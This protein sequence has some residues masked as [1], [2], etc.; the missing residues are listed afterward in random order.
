MEP[1]ASVVGA[2]RIAEDVVGQGKEGSEVGAGRRVRTTT[3]T[4]V[5]S[6]RLTLQRTMRRLAGGVGFLSLVAA[7]IGLGSLQRLAL[8]ERATELALRRA[9]GA[10][11]VD[12]ATLLLLETG[13]ITATAVML[14]TI[15]TLVG[16]AGLA[17]WSTWPVEINWTVIAAPSLIL[18]MTAAT[19]VLQPAFRAARIEP[20]DALRS[21]RA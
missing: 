4:D 8:L 5:M 13:V 11:R 9:L 14:G 10:R 2:A 20:A 19:S 6:A 18:M 1:G 16:L 21:T 15:L 12:V 3:A 17:R 7:G